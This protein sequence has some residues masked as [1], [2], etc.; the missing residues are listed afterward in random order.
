MTYLKNNYKNLK[1]STKKINQ[2]LCG[3]FVSV[4]FSSTVIE[5]SLHAKVPVI[6][7]DKWRRYKHCS[8]ST[9]PKKENCAIYY[10]NNEQDF[11]SCLQTVKN[12]SNPDFN[13][14][15][16]NIIYQKC[17]LS[18]KRYIEITTKNNLTQI[19]LSKTS[20]RLL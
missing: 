1:F 5:D 9:D 13:N 18:K 19:N 7:F 20:L 15:I 17:T 8:A 2:L 11:K 14:Y 6:L 10:I 4:S 16:F 12:S 3:S